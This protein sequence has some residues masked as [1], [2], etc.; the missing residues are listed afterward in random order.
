MFK[1]PHEKMR[2][3]GWLCKGGYGKKICVACLALDPSEKHHQ[4]LEHALPASEPGV[5][6]EMG[7]VRE[8]IDRYICLR[9]PVAI[10]ALILSG[11]F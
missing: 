2:L 1:E 5:G 10:N 11:N 3:A 4:C 8:H 9:E 7:R 6:M